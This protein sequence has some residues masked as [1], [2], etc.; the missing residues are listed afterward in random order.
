VHG[1]VTIQRGAASNG[2]GTP[3]ETPHRGVSTSRWTS[4]SLGAIIGQFK[5]VC[6]RRIRA[7]GITDFGW[8]PRF[9]DHVVRDEDSLN[10]IRQYIF[11]NPLKWELEKDTPENHWM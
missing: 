3:D 9:Y 4:G 1:I 10:R 7:L 6:T 2:I 5:G 8:Q 11:D